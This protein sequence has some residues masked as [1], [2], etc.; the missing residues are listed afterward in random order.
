[1]GGC[2]CSDFRFA[3]TAYRIGVIQNWT[4]LV[5]SVPGSTAYLHNTGSTYGNKA[6]VYSLNSISLSN[7]VTLK[8]DAGNYTVTTL[9]LANGATIL[10]GV[11]TKSA[12]VV[13]TIRI[14]ATSVSLGFNCLFQMLIGGLTFGVTDMTLE[15]NSTILADSAGYSAQRGPGAGVQFT[16]TGNGASYGGMKCRERGGE[17]ER[18]NLDYFVILITYYH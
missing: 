9:S 7:A 13:S 10:G 15:F 16:S 11:S 2:I 4:D 3:L 8:I 17:N 6:G 5:L 1:M 14:N 18:G 12:T